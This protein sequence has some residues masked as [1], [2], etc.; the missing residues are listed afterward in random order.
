MGRLKSAKA[1]G[2][3]YE[4]EL[5]K[6]L[7]DIIFGEEHPKILRAPLSAGGRSFAGGGSA[8]VNGTPDIWLEAK[9]TEKFAP[10][11]SM[12]QAEKGIAAKRSCEMPTV[13][14]RKNRMST[15][16]S[17]VVMRLQDW[18]KLYRAY[19]QVKGYKIKDDI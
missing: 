2:D 15:E 19:L 6:Y 18:I 1:K 17:L 14:N 10:Y 4:R 3:G 13:F 12:D 9:R 5:A 8:D 16:E 7:D 11:S